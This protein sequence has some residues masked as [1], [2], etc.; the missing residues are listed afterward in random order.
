MKRILIAEDK[1]SSRELLRT[2][3]ELQGYEVLEAG[4]GEQALH[5]VRNEHLHL[6]LLD[7]QMP[8]RDG[9]QVV[10]EIRSDDRLCT[11][12]VIALTANA[13]PEDR[14]RVL[15]AGFTSYVSKP[16]ALAELRAEIARLLKMEQSKEK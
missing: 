2:V 10:R 5:V 12:P 3:L 6:V 1:T 11:L 13:M 9:Y 15:A 4:D 14:E 16:V 7:L 8:L